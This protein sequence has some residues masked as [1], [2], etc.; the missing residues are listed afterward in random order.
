MYNIKKQLVNEM[1]FSLI[2]VKQSNIEI[3]FIN[4]GAT[5]YS[6]NIP[7]FKGNMENILIQYKNLEDY[8]ENARYLNAIIGPTAGRINEGEF[9]LN[10]KQVFL[11]KNFI[12]KHNLHGGEDSL[13]FKLFNYYI[14]DNLKETKV[15]FT[16]D[17]KEEEQNYPGN[18]KYKIIYTI[19][20][21]KLSIEYYAVTD[22]PTIINLTNH[23]YFN[24]SGN[25]KNNILNHKMEIKASNI[26][27]LN[28]ECIPIKKKDILE[29]KLDYTNLRIIK[30]NKFNGIDHPYLLDEVSI[31][32]PQVK[33]IDPISRRMVT[34]YTSYNTVVCYTDNY[35]MNQELQY[36]VENSKHMGICFETQ[37]PPNGINI[38]GLESSI[39]KPGEEYYH[40]T[41]FIFSIVK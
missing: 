35:P 25:L 4:Y 6:V 17:I 33:L 15:T 31:N 7:D 22:K 8:I 26:I 18:Q 30:D 14:E 40:Q 24:L 19:I 10:G 36:N 38:D 2:S 32:R 1:E 28:D 11:D 5:I 34:V 16:L 12:G 9:N 3:T 39:L 23:A 29:S 27:E 20:E 37:N 13:S 21:G 41:V